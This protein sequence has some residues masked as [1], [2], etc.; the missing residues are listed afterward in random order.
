[1]IYSQVKSPDLT[2]NRLVVHHATI[3]RLQAL[4]SFCRQML[5]L[6]EEPLPGAPFQD[7]YRALAG[8]HFN[9]NFTSETIPRLA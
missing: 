7:V 9:F 6:R 2:P 4:I 1:M 3:R 8:I 5:F